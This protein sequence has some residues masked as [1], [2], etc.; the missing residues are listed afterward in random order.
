MYFHGN[1][2]LSDYPQDRHARQEECIQC[3]GLS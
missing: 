1:S 3:H 2:T